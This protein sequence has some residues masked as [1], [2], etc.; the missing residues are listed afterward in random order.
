MWGFRASISGTLNDQ[1]AHLSNQSPWSAEVVVQIYRQTPPMS[2]RP[3]LKKMSCRP[4]LYIFWLLYLELVWES[5][6]KKKKKKTDLEHHYVA[7]PAWIC[8]LVVELRK[9]VWLR[10]I[11]YYLSP[12]IGNLVRITCVPVYV[13]TYCMSVQSQREVSMPSIPN[14]YVAAA[15]SPTTTSLQPVFLLA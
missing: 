3:F 10:L 6:S 15:W 13:W 2:C 9:Y 7:A 1:V 14:D 11:S 4:A 5:F 8:T 12:C